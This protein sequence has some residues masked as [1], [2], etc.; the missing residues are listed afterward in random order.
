MTQLKF[1]LTHHN[2]RCKCFC[3]WFH[4][5]W[6]PNKNQFAPLVPTMLLF[7]V[8]KMFLPCHITPRYPPIH[9][10]LTQSH[11]LTNQT[12][13]ICIQLIKFLYCHNWFLKTAT[14]W[15]VDKYNRLLNTIRLLGLSKHKLESQS[16]L[17]LWFT[18]LLINPW[19]QN[20]SPLFIAPLPN[21]PHPFFPPIVIH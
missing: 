3:Q 20:P 6:F 18:L 12:L 21:L 4:F 15:K 2:T 9:G 19:H 10:L 13:S 7:L 17:K 8:Q 5:E 1:L 14:T 16:P 11:L